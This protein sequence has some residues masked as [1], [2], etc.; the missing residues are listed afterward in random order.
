MSD[1]AL[2]RRLA[3]IERELL[4]THFLLIVLIESISTIEALRTHRPISKALLRMLGSAT[5]SGTPNA[6]RLAEEVYEEVSGFGGMKALRRS[7]RRKRGRAA[8][9]SGN[10]VK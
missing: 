7:M 2:E 1:S 9:P 4:E 5:R 8:G 10:G 6:R 3:K